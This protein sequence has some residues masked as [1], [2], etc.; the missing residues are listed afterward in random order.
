MYLYI[1]DIV[2]YI[3]IIS[4]KNKYRYIDTQTDREP[5]RQTDKKVGRQAQTHRHIRRQ[6]QATDTGR[7]AGR[8]AD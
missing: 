2:V 6:K 1:V 3:C 8:L 4:T 7:Q 5:D